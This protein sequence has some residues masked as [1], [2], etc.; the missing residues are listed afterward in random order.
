MLLNHRFKGLPP[1]DWYVL[2]AHLISGLFCNDKVRIADDSFSS[3]AGQGDIPT[4]SDL[5]LTSVLYVPNF[6]L[7]LL[8]IS[9]LTKNL[10]CYLTFFPSYYVFQDIATKRTI[11]LEHENDGL[12]ILD[13]NPPVATSVI[14]RNITLSTSNELF[15]WHCQLGH[16]SFSVFKK[17]FP[18]FFVPNSIISCED[19]QLA[20]H[21]WYVYPVS[22]NNKSSVPF[23]IMHSD[24]WGPSPTTLSGF[25]Y[26]VTCG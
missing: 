3:V 25:K 8:S 1:H 16:L 2:L 23:S 4:T 13:F 11:G 18:H 17:M 7:N 21:C 10:N 12:Y 9:H 15:T 14:K 24:V 22:K 20:K 19:C 26:F 6:A 5:S